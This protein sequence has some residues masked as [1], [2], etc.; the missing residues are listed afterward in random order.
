[1]CFRGGIDQIGFNGCADQGNLAFSAVVEVLD[2]QFAI[3][4]NFFYSQPKDPVGL[5]AR[6]QAGLIR[7]N[8]L[9][10]FRYLQFGSPRGLPGR[11]LLIGIYR[12]GQKVLPLRLTKDFLKRPLR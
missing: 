1:M 3:R 7:I 9:E 8:A 6:T 12:Y 5:D 2:Y 11:G 4:A 10:H